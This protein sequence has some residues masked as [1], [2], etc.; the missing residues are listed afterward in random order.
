MIETVLKVSLNVMLSYSISACVRAADTATSNTLLDNWLIS[1]EGS[2]K[3]SAVNDASG[4][5]IPAPK[6]MAP[7]TPASP[8]VFDIFSLTTFAPK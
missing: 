3:G 1:F 6:I 7:I 2:I 4:D 8:N 5:I